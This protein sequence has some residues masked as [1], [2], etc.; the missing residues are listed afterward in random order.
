M[1]LGLGKDKLGGRA[2]IIWIFRGVCDG[3][4]TLV[5]VRV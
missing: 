1:G 5:G 4:Y 3:I 2:E